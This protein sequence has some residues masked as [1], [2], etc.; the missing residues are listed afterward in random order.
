M[1]E[2]HHFRAITDTFHIISDSLVHKKR[3]DL[4]GFKYYD[5][6][7]TKMKQLTQAIAIGGDFDMYKAF[8]CRMNDGFDEFMKNLVESKRLIEFVTRAMEELPLLLDD[9]SSFIVS[10]IPF[11]FPDFSH[12]PSSIFDVFFLDCS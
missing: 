11:S 9:I 6:A 5:D 2:T 8:F 4:L 3:S 7:I 10:A 1:I 12:I